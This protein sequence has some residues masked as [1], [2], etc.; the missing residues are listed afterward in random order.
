MTGWRLGYLGAPTEIT[1]AC[2]KLQ[3]QFTSG[4]CSITQR[5]AISALLK[6]DLQKK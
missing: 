4:T 6:P 1:K 2:I 3:G 5:A